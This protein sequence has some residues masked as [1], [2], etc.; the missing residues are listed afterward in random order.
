MP[1][2]EPPV[3]FSADL[4]DCAA[5]GGMTAVDAAALFLDAL[6]RAGA[7]IVNTSVVDVAPV[8]AAHRWCRRERLSDSIVPADPSKGSL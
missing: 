7:T 6:R 5:L 2:R 3:L 4:A 8:V 1:R